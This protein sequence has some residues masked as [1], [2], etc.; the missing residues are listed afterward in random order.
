MCITQGNVNITCTYFTQKIA[1][2]RQS[3]DKM[4]NNL[5]VPILCSILIYWYLPAPETNFLGNE[6]TKHQSFTVLVMKLYF[7]V[8]FESSNTLQSKDLAKIGNIK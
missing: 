5:I 8:V 2:F 3:T 1:K 7:S 4:L 6:S